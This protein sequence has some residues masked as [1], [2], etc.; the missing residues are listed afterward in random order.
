M[1]SGHLHRE[2]KKVVDI[3]RRQWYVATL[4]LKKSDEYFSIARPHNRTMVSDSCKIRLPSSREAGD[5]VPRDRW[6]SIRYIESEKG[7]TLLSEACAATDS[8]WFSGHFP[9]EPILPGIAILSMIAETI[10]HYE[11][12]QGRDVKISGIRRVRFK[13]QVRPDELLNIS[14]TRASEGRDKVYNFTVE[15]KGKTVCKGTALA[16]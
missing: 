15:L 13:Q 16:S 5:R 1:E 11:A 7:G 9:G 6:C 14:L 4:L 12:A 10:R 2:T 8:P 3:S